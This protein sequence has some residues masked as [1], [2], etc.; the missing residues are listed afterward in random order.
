MKSD[1]TDHEASGLIAAFD[2]KIFENPANRYCVV[3]MKTDDTS[4]PEGA[5]SARRYADHRIRFTAVGYDLPFTDAVQLQVSGEWVK[6]KYGLQLQVEDWREVV[7]QTED[8]V[9]AYLGS[10]LIKGIGKKTAAQIV[11]RFGADTLEILEH[12]PER[13]LEVNGITENKLDAIKASYAESR[14]LRDVMALLAPFRLTLKMAAKIYQALGPACV[15]ILRKNPFALCRISG[16]GFRRVDAIAQKNALRPHDPMRIQGA[17]C[18]VLDEAR[19]KSGHLF[20]LKEE[21]L[22]ESLKLLNEKLPLPQ[23]RLNRE[24]VEAALTDMAAEGRIVPSQEAVY[25]SSAFSQEDDTAHSIARLLSQKMMPEDVSSVLA[26]AE[27][28]T[29][30][31]L[32]KKQEAAVQTAFA[33]PVSLITG[34]PG[35]GKTTVLKMIL[36]V[37]RMLHPG[38]QVLLMAPT[39]RASRRMAE[40]TG[41]AN[42]KTMHS[43]LGLLSEEDTD[44]R[45]DRS[46]PL[47]AG[48]VIV[49]EFSMV[50][51]WLAKQFFTRIRQGTRLVLV[52]DADQLP[53]VGAGNVF[54]ELIACGQIP[55]TV[56]D[57]LFRQ[58]GD[59]LIAYNA[60]QIN[61]GSTRLCYGRDFVF[62]NAESQEETARILQEQYRRE[63]AAHGVAQ[64]QILSPFRTEGAAGANNL[65]AAL[66]ETVNPFRAQEEEIPFGTKT[67]RIGDRV[68]QT[69]NTRKAFNGDL[70]FIRSVQDT[71][72]GREICIA[73]DDGRQEVYSME[74]LADIDLA[75]ATTIHKAMGSECDVILMPLLKAHTILLYRNL[76]YT[77]ITRARKKVILV[78]QKS[79]LFMT[80][81]R[82]NVSRRNTR[83]GERIQNYCRAFAAQK[84]PR[85]IEFVP[86]E[87]KTAG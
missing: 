35:T 12:A 47:D 49:D 40:S 45:T 77:G 87:W 20:L 84:K 61:E 74:E 55:V 36:A 44:S 79:V 82:S 52:G 39:G 80:V 57:R 33:S 15:D 1:S 67:F 24:E 65:N 72:D 37:D 29:G 4:V 75:Y 76:L 16:I 6:S 9:L 48:L 34:S 68:M 10:G 14:A 50:D 81:H 73:F 71:P 85:A 7:P 70:G 63:I 60:K 32:S 22:R 41:F 64:V 25:L 58:A 38:D 18:C 26:A 2:G 78:G 11:A 53:S 19:G 46:K 69:R 13:L 27:E 30:Q 28:H 42:A 21:L 51:M 23:S 62:L 83:L 66:R 86:E 43:S 56:L 3:R 59:S 17:V 31:I 54:R 5:R 8:G